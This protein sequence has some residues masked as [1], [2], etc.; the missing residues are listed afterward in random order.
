M[1]QDWERSVGDGPTDYE[2]EEPLLLRRA[3]EVAMT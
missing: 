1:M 2:F 3:S